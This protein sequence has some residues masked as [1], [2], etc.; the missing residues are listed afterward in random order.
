MPQV[1]QEDVSSM[2]S[3]CVECFPSLELLEIYCT[4]R[5][6]ET[7][8]GVLDGLSGLLNHPNLRRLTFDN[9]SRF[10]ITEANF[11]RKIQERLGQTISISYPE[12]YD[13]RPSRMISC[14]FFEEWT[15]DDSQANT[16]QTRDETS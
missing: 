6:S 12:H 10:W 7:S 1:E 15:E 8:D 13:G 5:Y 9:D 3:M 4:K 16:S 14:S 2:A 11:E